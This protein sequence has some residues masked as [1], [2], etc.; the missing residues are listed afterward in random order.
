MSTHEAQQSSRQGLRLEEAQQIMYG[1]GPQSGPSQRTMCR[2]QMTPKGEKHVQDH[3]PEGKRS[4]VYI[5]TPQEV[6][7]GRKTAG[8]H[9]GATGEPER[10]GE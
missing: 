10:T 3:N 8:G 2:V 1:E 5:T 9:F 7:E 6:N 4:R